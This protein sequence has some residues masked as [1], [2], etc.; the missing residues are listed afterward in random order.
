MNTQP[1]PKVSREDVLR[2]V[3]R[4]YPADAAARA[5]P[6]LDRYG[7]KPF[8]VAQPRVQL[9]VLKLAKGDLAA[10]EH[11][12]ERACQDFRDVIA[13]AEY[14]AYHAHSPSRME[15]EERENLIA[16]DWAQY[17]EWLS[18]RSHEPGDA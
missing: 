5:I 13:W 3:R 4:D 8:H 2:I 11:Y 17:Q 12:I 6:V 10:L 9:A 15:P 7:A 18:H 1:V 16:A 14:P